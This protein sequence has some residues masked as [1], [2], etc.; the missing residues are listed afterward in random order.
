MAHD[1]LKLSTVRF[2][3]EPLKFATFLQS[4]VERTPS[5]VYATWEKS[6]WA[7]LKYVLPLSPIHWRELVFVRKAMFAIFFFLTLE[8]SKPSFLDDALYCHSSAVNR[9]VKLQIGRKRGQIGKGWLV[10]GSASC[11][12]ANDLLISDEERKLVKALL[13]G[14][15]KEKS[16]SCNLHSTMTAID[17]IPHACLETTSTNPGV[18]SAFADDKQDGDRHEDAH[19][20]GDASTSGGHNKPTIVRI[21]RKRL[22]EPI[23]NLWLEVSHPSKRQEVFLSNLTLNNMDSTGATQ[24]A[25][26][27]RLFR[28]VETLTL[29]SLKDVSVSQLLMK[30]VGEVSLKQKDHREVLKRH[31]DKQDKLLATARK[32][33]EE[34]ARTARFEQIWRSRRVAED[35]READLMQEFFHLYDV[36]R[37]DMESAV[38]RLSEVEQAEREAENQLLRNYMPLLREYLPS[39]AAEL[40]L[41]PSPPPAIDTDDFVYDVYA[42]EQD[43]GEHEDFDEYPTVHVI[44]E[45]NYNWREPRDPDYDSEDSNDENNPINDYPEE[46]NDSEIDNSE[47]DSEES[48][49][50]ASEDADSLEEEVSRW[51]Y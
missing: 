7:G 13:G 34:G 18:Q 51:H 37:V 25:I 49:A 35:K 48:N 6:N 21:K 36:V 29:S 17:V 46:E 47:C 20:F 16:T 1:D 43:S 14:D 23:D 33:H 30:V 3:K 32:Q 44:E 10:F 9:L 38:Q 5:G 8:R 22:N 19:V 28:R 11:G 45:S 50:D 12:S 4:T 40:D 42:L 15:T 2:C 24:L 26:Q 27:K 41:Q 31:K 39:A